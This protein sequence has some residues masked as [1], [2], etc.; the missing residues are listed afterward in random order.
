MPHGG[1]SKC[2]GP[3]LDRTLGWSGTRQESDVVGE[4]WT[5]TFSFFLHLLGL[6]SKALVSKNFPAPHPISTSLCGISLCLSYKNPVG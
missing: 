6:S 5:D 4:Y 1:N 2:K 3:V